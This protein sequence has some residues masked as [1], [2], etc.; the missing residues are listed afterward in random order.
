MDKLEHLQALLDNPAYVNS[1]YCTAGEAS[2]DNF[3]L[4]DGNFLTLREDE[5]NQYTWN[6][7][8]VFSEAALSANTWR[9]TYSSIYTCTSILDAIEKIEKNSINEAQWSSIKGQALAIRAYRYLDAVLI[10]SP[11]Y[12]R[13]TSSTDLGIPLRLD[14]D[15]NLPSIRASVEETYNQIIRDAKTSIPLL[16]VANIN[17]Y[18]AS[19]PF[20]YGLLARTYLAMREYE[21][22]GLY[23]DSCLQLRN[24]LLDFNTINQ[25]TPYPFAELNEE[26]I[27]MGVAF[28]DMITMDFNARIDP[29]LYDSYSNNDLRKTL[30]FAPNDDSSIR[31]R[32]SYIGAPTLFMGF[33][34]SEQYLVRAECLAR[35]GR[36]DEAMETLNALLD[37]RWSGDT[38]TPLGA[39]SSGEA[40]QIILQERRKELVM[41]GLRWMDLKRLNKEGADITLTRTVDGQTY[42]LLPNDPRYALTIPEDVIA[43]SGMPQN[44][45]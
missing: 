21:Q 40:L 11:A 30:F 35:S 9:G 23:A 6:A 32:G 20:A 17:A 1:N 14:P 26:T 5:Q 27:F 7:S 16:P 19:K 36:I 42:Q 22:A 28:Y 43:L 13:Q 37:T 24:T 33:S 2:S 3:Y 8:H 41:R 29:S 25:S 34:T 45:R 38:F 18:R 31:F 4:T 39:N 10:W 44:P 15:F 12:D